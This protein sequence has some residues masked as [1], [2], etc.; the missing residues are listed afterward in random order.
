MDYINSTLD[1]MVVEVTNE[2]YKKVQRM[3]DYHKHQGND[4]IVKKI[5]TA[6]KIVRYLKLEKELSIAQQ[7]M[8]NAIL[9]YSILEVTRS[10][11]QVD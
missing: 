7:E 10:S 6:R 4:Y 3:R 1:E 2:S 5:D 9:Q 11:V 8:N